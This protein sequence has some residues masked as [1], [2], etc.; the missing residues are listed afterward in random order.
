MTNQWDPQQYYYKVMKIQTQMIMCDQVLQKEILIY[1][2]I[3][4]KQHFYI[5]LPLLNSSPAA[6]L[7][8]PVLY[9]NQQSAWSVLI[10]GYSYS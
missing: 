5:T 4:K 6:D 1:K 3:I 7:F 2:A 10:F 8:I 9:E